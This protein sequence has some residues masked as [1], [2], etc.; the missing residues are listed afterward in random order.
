MLPDALNASGVVLTNDSIPQV[1]SAFKNLVPQKN[2]IAEIT[3]ID[4]I[5]VISLT[6][7]D[8]DIFQ[9]NLQQFR[10]IKVKDQEGVYLYESVNEVS[11]IDFKEG[12]CYGSK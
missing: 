3:P 10:A 7:N 1:L 6:Y 12:E 9:K 2:E 4:A 11:K 5:S 8:F